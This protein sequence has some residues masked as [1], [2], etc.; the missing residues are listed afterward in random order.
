MKFVG[1]W[2]GGRKGGNTEA[3]LDV[4]LEEAQKGGAIVNKI[5][6]KDKSIAPCDG[7]S[8]CTETGNCIIDDDAQEI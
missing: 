6:L 7:C 5:P 1:I 3:L 2:G 8:G 4:A